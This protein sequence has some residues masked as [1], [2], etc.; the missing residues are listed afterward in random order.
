MGPYETCADM[1]CTFGNGLIALSFIDVGK[2]CSSREFLRGK[3]VFYA[4]R[5]NKILTNKI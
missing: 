5:E 4:I 1:Y 2:S 3:Y